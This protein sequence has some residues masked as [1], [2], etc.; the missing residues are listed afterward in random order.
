MIATSCNLTSQAKAWLQCS[1]L[2]LLL[3]DCQKR[4]WIRKNVY[5][6]AGNEASYARSKSDGSVRHADAVW[7]ALCVSRQLHALFDYALFYFNKF[8]Y[9]IK[10]LLL[11]EKFVEFN[12]KNLYFIR[13]KSTVHPKST[14]QKNVLHRGTAFPYIHHSLLLYIIQSVV[15]F[16]L[17][18]VIV[19][20]K[21]VFMAQLSS[22]SRQQP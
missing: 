17:R 18:I 7:M 5:Y 21:L 19:V 15:L 14:V 20:R 10:K 2:Q 9:I 1:I 13:Q 22:G 3:N 4:K 12:K 16:T 6:F 11:V 8:F